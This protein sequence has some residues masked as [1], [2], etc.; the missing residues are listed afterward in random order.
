MLRF[1]VACVRDL[2][3]G[4]IL[5]WQKAHTR[6]LTVD[7][8]GNNE[9]DA[10]A[11]AVRWNDNMRSGV[12]VMNAKGI[13]LDLFGM[14]GLGNPTASLDEVVNRLKQFGIFFEG[15]FSKC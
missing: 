13:R 4:V 12:R 1:L 11:K 6:G 8:R 5:R 10:M 3:I 7:G 14:Y 9:A 2:Q 15:D